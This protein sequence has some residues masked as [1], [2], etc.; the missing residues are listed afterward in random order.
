MSDA[1]RVMAWDIERMSRSG[2]YSPVLGNRIK[3]TNEKFVNFRKKL[4]ELK[5]FSAANLT[6]LL[7][8]SHKI[9]NEISDLDKEARKEAASQG[10]RGGFRAMEAESS[11]LNI[12]PLTQ[13]EVEKL[14][15]EELKSLGYD[16]D[17]VAFK[18]DKDN[19]QFY[20][21]FISLMTEMYQ[22]YEAL[23]AKNSKLSFSDASND[24]V[25]YFK[26][27]PGAVIN[28][29]VKE[30][31]LSADL[32]KAQLMRK[33]ALKFSADKLVAQLK[34]SATFNRNLVSKTT[35]TEKADALSIQA[36][37]MLVHYCSTIWTIMKDMVE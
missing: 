4:Y 31:G 21:A 26:S 19:E 14:F 3:T 27:H 30:L 36:H 9:R 22:V 11:S 29:L 13:E 32:T 20:R 7:E 28:N 23:K 10:P 25:R 24:I 37:N 12:S 33:L 5:D 35:A 15:I 34:G 1:T 2:P 8:A 6:A 17:L 16:F 18:N